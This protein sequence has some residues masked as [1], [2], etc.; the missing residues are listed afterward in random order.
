MKEQ[1]KS[2][3]LRLLE[4]LEIIFLPQEPFI[5]SKSRSLLLK[6]YLKFSPL[7]LSVIV[8]GLV[9]WAIYSSSKSIGFTAGLAIF[10]GALCYIG[11]LIGIWLVKKLYINNIPG[12]KIQVK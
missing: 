2:K 1:N 9:A 8:T 4:A 11:G 3:R 5:L 10:I 7:I 12:F 6:Y